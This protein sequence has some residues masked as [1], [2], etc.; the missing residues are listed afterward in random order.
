M[1]E[2]TNP[3]CAECRKSIS[4]Y[5]RFGL[6]DICDRTLQGSHHSKDFSFYFGGDFRITVESI[7]DQSGFCSFSMTADTY[8]DISN[9]APL[10]A[11]RDFL[12][13]LKLGD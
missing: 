5:R 2:E 7:F 11:L 10:I 12:N 8:G 1:T 6:C 13:S 4:Q 3:T 9:P